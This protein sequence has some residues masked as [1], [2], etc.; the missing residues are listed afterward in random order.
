LNGA[1]CFISLGEGADLYGLCAATHPEKETRG[2][3]AFL[4]ERETSGISV[5]RIENDMGL[6]GASQVDH[7][8]RDVS[9]ISAIAKCFHYDLDCRHTRAKGK[10]C[11]K[12]G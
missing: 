7:G 5:G 2:L 10:M 8:I 4:I 9:S 1:K 12:D 3:Y 11:A 6:R